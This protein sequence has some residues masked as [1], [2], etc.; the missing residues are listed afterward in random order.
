MVKGK[1]QKQKQRNSSSQSKQ[2]KHSNT[3]TLTPETLQTILI[4]KLDVGCDVS[5]DRVSNE[6]QL[7]QLWAGYG[8]VNSFTCYLSNGEEVLLVIKRVNPPLA[9]SISHDRKLRSYHIEASFYAEVSPIIKTIVTEVNVKCAIPYPYL[10]ESAEIEDDESESNGRQN[11]SFQFLLSDLRSQFPD[12][13]YSIDE[14][15]TMTALRWLASFH[16]IFW[17]HEAILSNQTEGRADE[18]LKGPKLWEHG[19]YWHL[20]TRLEEWE[21]IDSSWLMLKNCA[22]AI[23]ERM[24]ADGKT[25]KTLVHGDFKA[26]NVL[27]N[28]EGTDCGVVDFQYCG[29]GYGMK[30]VVMFIVSSMSSKTLQSL[31]VKGL[32]EAYYKELKRNLTRIGRVSEDRINAV[33]ISVLESQYKLA[34]LDYVRFMAGWG[35]WGSN[36]RYA[37][38][39]VRTLLD[40]IAKKEHEALSPHTLSCEQW[41]SAIKNY[42]P[43]LY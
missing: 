40:E 15:R 7:A 5:I 14:R 18:E 36:C 6:K 43:S 2:T 38:D 39:E 29:T 17:E 9:S 37:Q 30:D 4:P 24:K 22:F 16:A 12:E 32:L 35:F 10:I 27:F 34:L 33:T 13:C 8:S 41:R 20:D 21:D 11:P 1:K 42:F 28:V 19:G 3:T 23:D 26:A 31:G 25:M